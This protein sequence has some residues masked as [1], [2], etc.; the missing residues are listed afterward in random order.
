MECAVVIAA[1]LTRSLE[2]EDVLKQLARGFET[3]W[4]PAG[5]ATPPAKEWRCELPAA[6]LVAVLGGDGTLLEAVRLLGGRPTPI[7]GINLGHLGFIVEINPNEV[8]AE[9]ARFRTGNARLR[10]RMMLAASWPGQPEPAA[11]LNEAAVFPEGHPSI[12]SLSTA[13]DGEHLSAFR[14]DGLLIATPTGSTGHSLSAGGSILEPGISAVMVTPVC[15]HTL[16]L[17]PLVVGSDRVITVTLRPPSTSAQ[18]RL[19]GRV[20][21][22]LETGQTLT[23]SRADQ[24]VCLVASSQRSFFYLLQRKLGWGD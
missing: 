5:W 7:F 20:R 19:D 8:A 14:G 21:G 6:D 17:R 9:L 3:L 18:V 11:V 13:V 16:S 15:P 2:V 23:V 10:T 12:L 1:G 22:R 4:L 24:T